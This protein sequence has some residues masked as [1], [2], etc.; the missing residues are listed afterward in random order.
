MTL[1]VVANQVY[2]QYLL[3]DN[4]YCKKDGDHDHDHDHA[5]VKNQDLV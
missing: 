4:L 5:A 3:S 1:P 2:L